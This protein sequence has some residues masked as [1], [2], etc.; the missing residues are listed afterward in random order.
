MPEWSGLAA[1][2]LKNF[3][4]EVEVDVMRDR[5]LL[6]LLKSKGNVNYGMSGTDLEW[7]VQYKRRSMQG[8]ADGDTLTFARHNLWKVASLDW[9]GYASTDMMT[10]KE[11]L[12]NKNKEAIINRMDEIGKGLA[13][14]IN[15]NFC[16]EL[17]IDGN[18]TGNDKRIHGIESF[19]GVAGATSNVAGSVAMQPTDTYAGLVTTLGNYGGTWTGNW[20]K[21]VGPAEYDFFSP[22]I[23]DVTS[24]LATASGGWTSATATWASRNAEI[25]RYA[26]LYSQKNKSKKG[27]LDMIQ[28]DREM[29]RLA[30]ETQATKERI[31]VERS[32]GL[33]KL[34]FKD[35]FTLDGVDITT[36]FGMPANTGYGFN[37]NQVDLN[38][39][40]D[41]LFV[42]D[43][44]DWDI[45]SRSWRFAIDFFGNCRFRPR[46]FVKIANYG[47][48]TA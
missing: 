38:S 14:D 33:W 30:Q 42:A 36:E 48:S 22:L 23:L 5:K 8:M 7:R 24:T 3:L 28:V 25:L 12:M 16:D 44:K 32:D 13:D 17:Y 47:S 1:T 11:R 40:Q 4:K 2:T 35:M 15:E 6:A 29:F 21:G 18:A 46:Y 39:L 26:I 41:Q 10:K 27:M 19:L 34:G 37:A 45:A 43:T 20:P 31:V 9:R